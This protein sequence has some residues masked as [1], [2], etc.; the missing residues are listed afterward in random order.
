MRRRLP[1]V[2]WNR[3]WVSVI[4]TVP[5][6]VDTSPSTH[7]P[8]SIVCDAFT[9]VPSSLKTKRRPEPEI[10]LPGSGRVST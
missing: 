6:S 8:S 3:S 9:Y 7:G 1:C 4:V 10:P 5:D 2:G